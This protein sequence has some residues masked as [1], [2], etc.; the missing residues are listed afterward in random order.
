MPNKKE[1]IKLKPLTT[2]L[3]L[4]IMAGA[5]LYTFYFIYNNIYTTL[6]N[7][8]TIFILNNELQME[9]L[10]IKSFYEME[11]IIESKNNQ[12]ALPKEIRNIFYYGVD[13]T[14]STTSTE[15]TQ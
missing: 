3:T 14:T 12:Q 11:K 9:T 4:G 10:D 13:N 8:R 2:I 7:A 5:L 1:K 6:N 15:E